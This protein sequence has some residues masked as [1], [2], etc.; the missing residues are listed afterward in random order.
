M[1]DRQKY[2]EWVDYILSEGRIKPPRKFIEDYDR[3]EHRIML[4][5]LLAHDSQYAP[6]IELFESVTYED[7]EDIDQKIWALMDLGIC[8][9]LGKRDMETAIGC[10]DVALYLAED[11]EVKLKFSR[12]G[13]I[14]YNRLKLIK[15]VYGSEQADRE[16]NDT[17]ISQILA[18]QD[19]K[20]NSYLYYGYI[21]KG[22]EERQKGN[23]SLA[24]AYIKKAGAYVMEDTHTLE[25][26][27]M[28]KEDMEDLDKAYKRI[29]S[30]VNSAARFPAMFII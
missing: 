19:T 21:Y 5:R 22:E 14:W 28:Y 9:W 16:C 12:R 4:G 11:E 26:E 25:V 20:Y 29:Y 17:M 8:Y 7:I 23:L 18:G 30:Y 2:S 1:M 15:L 3:W 27:Y 10:L 13:E 6:A 24:I